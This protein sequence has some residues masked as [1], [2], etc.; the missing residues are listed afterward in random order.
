VSSPLGAVIAGKYEVKRLLGQGGMGAVYEGVHI[1]I[2]KRVAIKVIEPSHAGSA[3]VAARFKQE[4]RAASAVESD[5]VVQVFDVGQDP[6]VGLYMVMEFLAGEDLAVRIGR[7]RTLEPALAV[8]ITT[9]AARALA[10]AHA[11]GVVHRDLK[12]ANL[13]LTA[14]EDGLVLVKILDFGISKLMANTGSGAPT[15]S[16]AITRE[17]TVI[18]T[19]QYMSPEQAQGL[20]VDQRTD[21]WSLGAVLYEALAGRCPYP[22]KATYEQTIIQIVTTRPVPLRD[23]APW[24]S[25]GLAKLVHEAL[26]PEVDR[27][28]PD[29]ATFARRLVEV[30][31]DAGSFAS[32][33]SP[34]VIHAPGSGSRS[35]SMQLGETAASEPPPRLPSTR[36]TGEGVAVKSSSKPRASRGVRVGLGVASVVLL[37]GGIFTM[38][39]RHDASQ[40]PAAIAPAASSPGA[41]PPSSAPSATPAVISASASE[42]PAPST[43]APPRATAS[44]PPRTP[45]PPKPEPPPPAKPQIGGAGIRTTY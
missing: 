11:A 13:F 45:A 44:A 43:S 24:V 36:G 37:G 20:A 4:A 34:V 15:A 3:E 27:R 7:D 39:L 32:R 8:Q 41:P 17:G 2:G 42:P 22:E 19:A 14:R 35:I 16:R 28:L 31:P 9:Q 30:S 10:K 33:P 29:C 40:A 18:G 26:T 12:P 5:C 1:E 38:A 21:V 6:V 25:E 23:V